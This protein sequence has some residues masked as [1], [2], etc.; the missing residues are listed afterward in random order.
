M[1]AI[2]AELRIPRKSLCLAV[3]AC[4]AMAAHGAGPSGRS[5]QDIVL[6]AA[7]SDIDYRANKLHF[8]DVV[9]SQGDTRIQASEAEANGTG[10]KFDD[11]TWQF[12]GDV[13]IRFA[14]GNLQSDSA[15]VSFSRNRIA[16]ASISGSPAQFEQRVENLPQPARGR[17]NRI[18]YDLQAGTVRLTQNAWLSDGR[19]EISSQVLVYNLKDQKVQTENRAETG[20]PSAAGTEPGLGK[21]RV[22]ITIRPPPDAPPATAPAP[23]P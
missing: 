21:G 13:R 15:T 2:H 6:D 9:I 7:S 23:A 11:S 5:V 18:D 20:P 16:Q 3:V 12:R 4:G 8:R 10:L 14:S 17:A 19:S 22:H 1:A